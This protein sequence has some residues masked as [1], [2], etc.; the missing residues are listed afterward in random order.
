MEKEILIA[1]GS[2]LIGTALQEHAIELGYRVTLLSR[3]AGDNRIKWD[4]EA[5]TI[6]LPVKMRFDAIINLAGASLSE[7][8]WT[9]KNKQ[10]IYQSRIKSC[11]TLENYL[12]DGRLSTD[13][14]VGASAVG[15]YGDMGDAD[16][17]EQTKVAKNDWFSKTVID[18]E[19][20]HRRIETLEIRTIIVRI[21]I[22]LS[23]KGGALKEILQKVSLG[24][25]PYF[26]NGKQFWP[27]IH[28]DD[29]VRMIFY[30][31]DHAEIHGTYLAA[32][33]YPATNKKLIKTINSYLKPK[34][35][36]VSVPRFILKLML[37][38]M[39]RVVFDSCKSNSKKIIAAGFQ[40][41][42]PTID[43]AA[44][45]IISHINS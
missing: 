42:F 34:K 10:G 15:I 38:E 5:G 13:V 44:K 29:L 1:G 41:K 22:V 16:V 7:G 17:D 9:A 40:F 36:I 3:K 33:P 30:C 39:H 8:R 43:E 45:E 20:G 6:D 31:I 19:I 28:I 14:Y 21:G 37:G 11:R 26:G 2:G 27:W 4:P 35:L 23:T 12:F 32:A 18:W 24:I 25:I